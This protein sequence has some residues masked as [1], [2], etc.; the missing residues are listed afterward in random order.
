MS[1]LFIVLS[2]QQRRM[3]TYEM[4]YFNSKYSYDKEVPK[5][6]VFVLWTVNTFD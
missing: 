1:I 3:I 5:T 2:F 6:Y 4:T